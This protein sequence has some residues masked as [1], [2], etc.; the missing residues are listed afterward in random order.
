LEHLADHL[1]DQVVFAGEVVADHTLADAEPYR[2][3]RT[4]VE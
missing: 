4:T 2:D 3:C 1:G